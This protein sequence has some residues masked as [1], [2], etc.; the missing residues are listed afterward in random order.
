MFFLTFLSIHVGLMPAI[1]NFKVQLQALQNVKNRI[2]YFTQAYGP[3]D[4]LSFVLCFCF[5]LCFFF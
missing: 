5:F 4:F 3:V 1:E 2:N